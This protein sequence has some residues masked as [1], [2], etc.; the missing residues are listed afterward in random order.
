MDGNLSVLDKLS[1]A[2]SVPEKPLKIF[3]F[4]E[5]NSVST[6]QWILT[7]V[8]SYPKYISIFSSA[9]SATSFNY[10]TSLQWGSTSDDS[11]MPNRVQYLNA[12]YDVM[13]ND[14]KIKVTYN[15]TAKQVT[16]DLSGIP[17]SPRFK[18]FT[19]YWVTLIY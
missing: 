6:S 10:V 13:V 16:V 2:L 11:Y 19:R 9:Q 18:A 7:D 8:E 3:S 4:E 5:E 17:D 12:V 15:K 1:G 14:N